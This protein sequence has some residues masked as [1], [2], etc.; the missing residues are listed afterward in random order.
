MPYWRI[1]APHSRQAFFLAAM[2]G[3]LW[4][5]IKRLTVGFG[6]VRMFGRQVFMAVR[7][8]LGVLRPPDLS[9]RGERSEG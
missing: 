5:A 6:Q 2:T 4:K 1:N 9:G 8:A 3:F 7:Q